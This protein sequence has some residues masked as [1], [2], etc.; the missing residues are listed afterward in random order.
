M[1]SFSRDQKEIPNGN[2]NMEI[3]CHNPDTCYQ[4]GEAL[5]N[6]GYYKEALAYFDRAIELQRDDPAVWVFR[7]VVLLHLNRNQEALASCDKALEINP[8]DREAWTFRGAALHKL[9]RYGEAYDSYDRAT[10][11]DARSGWRSQLVN[12]MQWLKTYSSHLG[13]TKIG[14]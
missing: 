9:G 5:A 6:T 14:Q 13:L 12:L 1:A 3:S 11:R 2:K 10:G 7:G 4:R 8:Y